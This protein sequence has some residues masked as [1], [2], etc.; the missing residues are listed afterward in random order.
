VKLNEAVKD[1]TVIV[2]KETGFQE[3]SEDYIVE[4]LESRSVIL[5][6]EEPAGLDRQT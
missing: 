1:E 6:N 3:V 5:T 4:W 2:A